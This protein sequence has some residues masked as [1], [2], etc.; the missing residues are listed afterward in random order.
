MT[1]PEVPRETLLEFPCRFPI[2]AFGKPDDDFEEQVYQLIKAH[3]PEL[4]RGD[5]SQRASSGGKYVAIT[6]EI[7]AQS[8]AQLDA[9]YGDLSDNGTVLMAL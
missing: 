8:Q 3:V 9:I 6:A 5:L 7:T 2:K 1:E 4:E